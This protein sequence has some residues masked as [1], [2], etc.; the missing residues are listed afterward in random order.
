[1][2]SCPVSG[3]VSRSKLAAAASGLERSRSASKRDLGLLFKLLSGLGYA[4]DP[5]VRQLLMDII[6][7]P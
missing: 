3:T 4:N 7:K 1:M 6:N 5:R 2:M